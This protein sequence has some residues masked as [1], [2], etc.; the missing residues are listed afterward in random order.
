MGKA[1]TLAALLALAACTTTPSGSFC[2]L[3]RHKE[4]PSQAEIDVMSEA[5]RADLLAFYLKGERLCGWK[6]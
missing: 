4:R 6:T 5:R 3:A 1:L 2:D